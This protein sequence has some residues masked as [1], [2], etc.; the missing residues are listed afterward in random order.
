MPKLHVPMNELQKESRADNDLL[1][2]TRREIAKF[3]RANPLKP[4]P[5][6]LAQKVA[7]LKFK[8]KWR[9]MYNR[10]M[11]AGVTPWI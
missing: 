4:I 1:T 9:G 11:K 7:E 8:R 6:A 10:A 5:K 3:R 2:Q